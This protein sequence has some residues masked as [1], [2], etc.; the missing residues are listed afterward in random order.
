MAPRQAPALDRSPTGPDVARIAI[1][2]SPALPRH[3]PHFG[4]RRQVH[5]SAAAH[6]FRD[7]IKTCSVSHSAQGVLG[8]AAVLA[9]LRIVSQRREDRQDAGESIQITMI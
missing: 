3:W 5:I 6:H 2:H 9:A 4:L 7:V 8:E 1:V